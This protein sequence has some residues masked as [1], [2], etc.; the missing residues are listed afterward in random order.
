MDGWIRTSKKTPKDG[1]APLIL[2]KDI[3]QKDL[4]PP[5]CLNFILKE[6]EKV[7]VVFPLSEVRRAF[8]PAFLELL[9]DARVSVHGLDLVRV[10]FGICLF[11]G[12]GGCTGG[13]EGE[14]E[15]NNL[16]IFY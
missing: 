15:V 14:E 7:G 1:L 9:D 8:R 5:L 4:F 13:V 10:V 12:A 16:D 6:L 11:E 3:L 2:L